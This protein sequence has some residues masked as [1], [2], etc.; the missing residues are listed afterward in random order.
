MD[1]NELREAVI[2][3]YATAEE[4]AV[5]V[6]RVDEFLDGNHRQ[7]VGDGREGVAQGVG[8]MRSEE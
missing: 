6:E 8:G 4:T 1:E 3:L 7:G 5:G 2:V